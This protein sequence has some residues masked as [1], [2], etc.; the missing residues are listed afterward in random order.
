METAFSN[1]S[2]KLKKLVQKC[3][4]PPP[5]PTTI[6]NLIRAEMWLF[7]Y[8]PLNLDGS[9]LIFFFHTLL[10]ILYFFYHAE[11]IL[12]QPV[13]N[14]FKLVDY[15]KSI[16]KKNVINYKIIVI[17]CTNKQHNPH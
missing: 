9:Q 10:K 17:L 3:P 15:I 6:Y 12:S 8:F 16:F 13:F 4:L 2:E 14:S 7:S 11:L 5:T 1:L